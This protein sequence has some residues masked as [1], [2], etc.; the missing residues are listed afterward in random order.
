MMRFLAVG[1]CLGLSAC[2]FFEEVRDVFEGLTNPLVSLGMVLGVEPSGGADLEGTDYE[3]GVLASVFLA[4]AGNVNQIDQAPVTGAEVSIQSVAAFDTSTGLYTILPTDGLSYQEEATWRLRIEIGDGAATANLH[5]PAAASFAPPTQHTAG[6]DLEVDVSG[7]DFHSLLVVVLEAESGDVTWSNEPE[8]A[9]EFYDFT[10]GST[11]ELAVTI[12]GD[13]A[14]PNQSA[15][16]VG[17]AGMKHTGASD[18]TRMNTALSTLMVGKMVMS[19]IS[20]LP[21]R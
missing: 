21:V 10:H 8:T 2:D 6:A 13:E 11:E 5:L 16:V 18:L 7:Q 9:R 19:P 1:L 17:V 12:P 3:E 4:D 20:T 15:Y 14:F